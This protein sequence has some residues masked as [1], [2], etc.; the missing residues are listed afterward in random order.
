MTD[1]RINKQMI[2]LGLSGENA[3]TVDK[4]SPKHTESL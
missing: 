1:S 2:V 3:M 4:Q